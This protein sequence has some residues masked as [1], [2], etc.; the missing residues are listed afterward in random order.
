MNTGSG[1]AFRQCGPKRLRFPPGAINHREGRITCP[2]QDINRRVHPCKLERTH[3]DLE[4]SLS[5]ADM[6]GWNVDSLVIGLF[7]VAV[8]VMWAAMLLRLLTL[9]CEGMITLIQWQTW[10]KR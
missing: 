6:S 10:L 8:G 7:V 3:A 2:D 5:P 4:E 9:A 1:Q